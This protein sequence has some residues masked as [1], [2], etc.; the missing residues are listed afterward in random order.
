MTTL[1]DSIRPV[2]ESTVPFLPT[3]LRYGLI[4]GLIVMVYGFIANM[5][6]LS[7]PTS[8]LKSLGVMVL[9]IIVTVLIG[10]FTI[11][12]HRDNELNGFISFGRAFKLVFVTFLIMSVF[13][14]FFNWFY[15]AVIDPN[16]VDDVI[17]AM[18]DMFEG[19]GMP[20]SE[21]EKQIEAAK[22][23]FTP[24]GIFSTAIW[25]IVFSAVIGLIQAAIM[26]KKAP[27]LTEN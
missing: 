22:V 3:A 11:K 25:A 27:V 16:F 12:H 15:S 19:M 24:E 10:Y 5:T 18:T 7:L 2:E 17:S 4:G 26:K 1:D 8:I 14:T 9:G 6:G 21:M 23:R 13:S 20:E